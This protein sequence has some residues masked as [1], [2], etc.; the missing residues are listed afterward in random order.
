MQLAALALLLGCDPSPASTDAPAP[1][2]VAIDAIDPI[3]IDAPPPAWE[4]VEEVS[5]S[6]G[7][8]VERVGYRSD[9]L[10]IFAKQCR[11]D[12][13][14]RH[15][16]VVYNH[17]GF[18][19]LAPDSETAR[20]EMTA[21][22]GYVW[23]GSSYRGED[24]SEGT[25]EVCLGEV[26]DVLAM[27]RIGAAQPYATGDVGMYGASHGGCI[28]QRALQRGA[29]VKVAIDIFGPTD[30]TSLYAYWQARGSS[31]DQQLMSV[32]ETATGGTPATK[33]D[34]YAKRSPINFVAAFPA[35]VPLLVTHGTNDA[36]VPVVQ[37]CNL[38]MPA[39]LSS[40]HVSSQG[41]ELATP[42]TTCEQTPVPSN[43]TPR[44]SPAWPM[45][46]Y[47]VIYDGMNHEF[48]S[49]SAQRMLQDAATFLMAKL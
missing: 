25:V 23:L 19:G 17:G 24:R 45:N 15:A 18:A 38:A 37:S 11:P 32:L 30:W 12:D 8:I 46:R 48:T 28:T 2:A 3:G 41:M 5:R 26:D 35:S 20:C 7:V 10:L 39:M 47:L 6:G 42:P 1:D 49:V 31:A 36:I 22:L 16:I 29:P 13:T 21:Q 44:P 34:E 27:I 9:G 40:Y 4:S 43:A 33:P 14:A